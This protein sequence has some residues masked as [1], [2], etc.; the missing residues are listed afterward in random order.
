MPEG[1]KEIITVSVCY[2]CK[3]LFTGDIK[4]STPCPVCAGSLDHVLDP[5]FM[6][7]ALTIALEGQEEAAA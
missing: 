7:D 5:G 4:V 6:V 2:R 3:K 1:T